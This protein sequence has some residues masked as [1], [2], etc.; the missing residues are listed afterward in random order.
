MLTI[1]SARADDAKD[2]AALIKGAVAWLAELGSDQWQGPQF[3]DADR[4]VIT[5]GDGSTWV[6]ESGTEIVATVSL[7]EAADPEFWTEADDPSSALYLHR[8]VVARSHAREHLGSSIIDWASRQA[9]ARSKRWLRLDAWSSNSG[10]HAYYER[11]GF[12]NVRTL[13][14]THRGSGA[15]FQ[16]AAGVTLD[17]GPQLHEITPVQT[18]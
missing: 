8:M 10:L 16:K 15:L 14:Y 1:R 12:T 3:G 17:R 6:V 11:Q 7:D 5:L 4:I 18:P 13:R 2:V 9:A